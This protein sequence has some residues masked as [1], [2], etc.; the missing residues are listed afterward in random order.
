MGLL[1]PYAVLNFPPPIVSH[2][3]CTFAHGCKGCSLLMLP[4]S[5]TRIHFQGL[6]WK[7]LR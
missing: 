2:A 1:D 6:I 3:Q 4:L 7:V 5:I